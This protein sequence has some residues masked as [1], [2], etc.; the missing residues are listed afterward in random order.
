MNVVPE[1]FSSAAGHSDFSPSASASLYIALIDYDEAL[2]SL[3]ITILIGHRCRRTEGGQGEDFTRYSQQGQTALLS[4]THILF[5]LSFFFIL[6]FWDTN[7]TTDFSVHLP[8]VVIIDPSLT[9][10]PYSCFM[11]SNRSR[12]QTAPFKAGEKKHELHTMARLFAI[13]D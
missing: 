7:L 13:W 10:N 9:K 2:S 4:C 6:L 5:F 11:Q 1:T 3:V 12:P 8:L